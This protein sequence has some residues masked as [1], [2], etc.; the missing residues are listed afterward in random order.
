MG[1]TNLNEGGSLLIYDSEESG[2]LGGSFLFLFP[3]N[4]NA[5]M[6]MG[7]FTDAPRFYKDGDL[8]MTDGDVE[9]VNALDAVDIQASSSV[10]LDTGANL[11]WGGTN[12]VL[13]RFGTIGGTNSVYFTSNDVPYHIRLE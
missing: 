12:T 8:D 2:A 9:N 5:S 6:M 7:D 10:Q 13:W 11:Q 3:T 4:A 1:H